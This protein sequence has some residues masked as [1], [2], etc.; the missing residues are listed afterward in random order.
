MGE[1]HPTNPH[2]ANPQSAFR[3]PQPPGPQSSGSL[4][5]ARAVFEA[6]Y[7]AEV[8]RRTGG[9]VTRAAKA[10]GLS[11]PVLHQKIKQYGIRT[12]TTKARRSRSFESRS[13][14]ADR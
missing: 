13:P 7:I 3:I 11:R 12:F 4:R 9:N 6:Q 1:A 8:L 2:P 5:A 14:P 10:L